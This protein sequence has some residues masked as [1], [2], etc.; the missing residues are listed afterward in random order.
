MYAHGLYC[1][2]RTSDTE[3]GYVSRKLAM[4]LTC[5]RHNTVWNSS[6]GDVVSVLHHREAEGRSRLDPIEMIAYG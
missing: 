3:L 5:R 2:E 4:I 1:R 6:G